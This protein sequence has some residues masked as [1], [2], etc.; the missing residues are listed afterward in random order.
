[1]L[2]INNLGFQLNDLIFLSLV[3]K[4]C[5]RLKTFFSY[6]HKFDLRL[7]NNLTQTQTLFSF[8]EKPGTRYP[9]NYQL[10][11]TN[12]GVPSRAARR[13]LPADQPVH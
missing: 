2:S 11:I 10:P 1:M 8:T 7:R 12:N 9:T 6:V 13:W 3:H 4:F 5:S